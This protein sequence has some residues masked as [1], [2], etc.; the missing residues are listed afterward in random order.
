MMRFG[1]VAFLLLVLSLSVFAQ[2][3]ALVDGLNAPRGLFYDAD[4]N[5]WIVEAGQ[6]GELT[7]EGTFGPVDIGGT[8]A[9]QMLASD[10]DLEL[11]IQNLPSQGPAGQARGA[12]AVMVTDESIWLLIGEG[13]AS[14]PL[15]NSLIEINRASLRIVNTVDLY[16]SEAEL[17]PDGDIV[18]ANATDFVRAEDGTFYI[19]NAG[20]NCIQSWAQGGE[21]QIFASWTMDDNPVPTGIALAPDG[22]LYV[23]FLS[24]WPHDEGSARIEQWSPDGTLLNTF[25]GL[26]ALTDVLVAPDGSVYAVSIGTNGD[27]GFSNGKVLRVSAD[28]AAVLMEGLNMPWGLALAPDGTLVVSVNSVGE[29]GMVLPVPMN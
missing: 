21:V 23:S 2:D 26:T 11:I 5:L 14:I 10:G 9:L 24:G 4:G 17:N 20:C 28:G 27:A 3:N 19:A 25:S 22:S 12:S 18:S 6:G 29:N 15:T 8:G 1:F 7:A 16:S 13:P